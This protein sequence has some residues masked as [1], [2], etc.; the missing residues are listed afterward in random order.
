MFGIDPAPRSA[1]D[2]DGG[3][4][5]AEASGFPSPARDYFNGGIDLNRHLIRDRTCTF[6]MR[7]A[8]NAMAAAGI[9]DGD[10]LIVDRSLVPR[11]G[12]V[13]VAVLDGELV[14]RRLRLGGRGASLETDDGAGATELT[15]LA[16]LTVWGVATRCLHRV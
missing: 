8:G 1:P 9:A 7:V 4:A 15:E 2:P 6:I 12:S 3:G 5:P 11:D 16:D 13:V 10:E 14:V